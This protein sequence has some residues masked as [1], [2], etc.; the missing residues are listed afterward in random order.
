[1]GLWIVAAVGLISQ[2]HMH[3]HFARQNFPP[4]LPDPEQGGNQIYERYEEVSFSH[5]L[6]RKQ[7]EIINISVTQ[8]TRRKKIKWRAVVEGNLLIRKQFTYRGILYRLLFLLSPGCRSIHIC[9][10]IKVIRYL[11]NNQ[12]HVYTTVQIP[13]FY[14]YFVIQLFEAGWNCKPLFYKHHCELWIYLCKTE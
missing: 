10:E 5:Q 1:M 3:K 12:L 8:N 11:I 6:S 9:T 14:M 2:E 7:E 4:S 13:D